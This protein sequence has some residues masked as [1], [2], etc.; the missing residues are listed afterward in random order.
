[1]TRP[2]TRKALQNSGGFAG[3]LAIAV[4]SGVACIL[5]PHRHYGRSAGNGPPMRY[6]N[7]GHIDYMINQSQGDFVQKIF[8]EK[9]EISSLYSN[10]TFA[11]RIPKKWASFRWP[12]G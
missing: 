6:S 4:R 11:E 12:E 2:L 7:Q 3:Q 1:M 8:I 9:N 10:Y 5:Q